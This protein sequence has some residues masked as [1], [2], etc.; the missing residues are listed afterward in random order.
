MESE[1]AAASLKISGDEPMMEV[2][3]LS[4]QVVA[5]IYLTTQAQCLKDVRLG[6]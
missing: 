2:P 6:S 1:P 5:I 3:S 4:F